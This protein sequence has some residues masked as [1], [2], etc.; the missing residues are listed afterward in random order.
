MTSSTYTP[1]FRQLEHAVAILDVD[2]VASILKTGLRLSN[3]QIIEIYSTLWRKSF[4]THVGRHNGNDNVRQSAKNVLELLACHSANVL[5]N[6]ESSLAPFISDWGYDERLIG[7]LE[8]AC[9]AKGYRND[10]GGSYL[11]T[12]CHNSF[13]H[14]KAIAHALGSGLFSCQEEDNLGR[15][16][17]VIMWQH[18]G[19]HSPRTDPQ[20]MERA[21]AAL[22]SISHRMI[23][24][25]SGG[26]SQSFTGQSVLRALNHAMYVASLNESVGKSGIQQILQLRSHLERDMIFKELGEDEEQNQRGSKKM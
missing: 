10:E 4:N 9:H 7:S 16:P 5:K 20:H 26:L 25:H 22:V 15:I 6:P 19:L 13:V 23:N 3:L 11:H 21:I 8:Q 18:S 14:T 1:N 12:I 17:M 2:S 24:L